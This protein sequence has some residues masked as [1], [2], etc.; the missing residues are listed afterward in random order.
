MHMYN[1]FWFI[2]FYLL[3]NKNKLPK[4]YFKNVLFP[5]LHLPSKLDRYSL[6]TY[7]VDLNDKQGL[8]T[9]VMQNKSNTCLKGPVSK[10]H[11][12][13]PS[14]NP[15][16]EVERDRYAHIEGCQERYGTT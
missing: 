9:P 8:V 11:V 14:P 2:L 1:D 5:Y 13:G 3:L 4:L 16:T 15:R 10:V 7:K 12:D 6:L